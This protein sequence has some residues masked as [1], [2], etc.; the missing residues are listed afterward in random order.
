M[1]QIWE[2]FKKL[3][4]IVQLHVTFH[5]TYIHNAESVLQPA[6]THI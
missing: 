3:Q 1:Q 5:Y 6:A 2:S 4:P